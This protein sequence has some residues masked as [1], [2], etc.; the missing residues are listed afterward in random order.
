[1]S[2]FQLDKVTS[3][4]DI[5]KSG[6]IH[7]IGICGA[8]MGQLAMSLSDMGYIVSGSDK[9]FYDPMATLLKRS[10]LELYSGYSAS[11]V[12]SDVDLFIIGNSVSRDNPEVVKIEEMKQRY[13]CLPSCIA[14]LLVKDR[15]PIVITGTHGKSTTTALTAHILRSCGR[16]PG[17][18][19][20]ARVED[21][22]RSFSVG[23]DALTVIEGDE[24]DSAFFAKVPKFRFYNPHILVVTS[25]EYDHA[26]IYTDLMSIVKEFDE[27]IISRSVNDVIIVCVDNTTIA[28]RLEFWRAKSKARI[29][30]YGRSKNSDW[31]I[32]NIVAEN[33]K[34]SFKIISKD[35][36]EL[37]VSIPLLGQHNACNAT[38]AIL[39]C[40]HGGLELEESAQAVTDFKGV[41]RRLTKVYNQDGIVVYED[42]AHHPTAVAAT[43]QGV[44][45]SHPDARIWAV[46]DP[47]SNTSRKKIFERDYVEALTNADAIIVKQVVARHND[48]LSDLIDVERIVASLGER[49]RE[50]SSYSSS[51]EIVDHL[52]KNLRDLDVVLIMSNGSFDG[53]VSKILGVLR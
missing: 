49:G 21:S 48:D 52:V 9:E 13:T 24:Y 7:L 31:Q 2:Y 25:I 20:G 30:S 5:K 29:I 43:I 53:L 36:N 37:K 16:D 15:R 42:F 46:F 12:G 11:N 14:D 10:R 1:M 8:A 28:E 4:T 44:R 45:A 26:D 27:L 35:G 34:T 41:R 3:L 22:E 6:R 17:F 19:I 32:N 47:R 23:S 50:S 40:Y 18:F 38:A 39:A 33:D 51:D